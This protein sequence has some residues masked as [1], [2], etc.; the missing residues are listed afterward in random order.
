MP[1]SK[2]QDLFLQIY[3]KIKEAIKSNDSDV[4]LLAPGTFRIKDTSDLL[5]NVPKMSP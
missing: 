1:K 2:C 4:D 5:K 3:H